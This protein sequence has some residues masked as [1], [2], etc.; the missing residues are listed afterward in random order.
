MGMTVFDHN[1]LGYVSDVIMDLVQVGRP[2]VSSPLPMRLWVESD[3]YIAAT[4]RRV[5][6]THR[7]NQTLKIEIQF[8]KQNAERA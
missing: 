4:M 5:G 3:C 8:Q 7:S 2:G 6:T 1:P